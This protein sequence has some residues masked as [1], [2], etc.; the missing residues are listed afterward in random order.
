M[1]KLIFISLLLGI[2]TACFSQE[3][4]KG[5]N[6]KPFFGIKAGVN[7]INSKINEKDSKIFFGYQIGTTLNIPMSDKFS[8]QPELAIQSISNGY[9]YKNEY[10]NGYL[11]EDITYRYLF[12][13]IPLDFKYAISKKVNIDFGPNIAY[14]LSN[15]KK[16]TYEENLDGNFYSS[17]SVKNV[18]SAS[19]K[20]NFGANLGVNYNFNDKVYTGLRYTLFISSYQNIRDTMSNSV[21]ALSVG[22]NFN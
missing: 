6:N 13:N 8:F 10:S 4:E 11:I 9:Y 16:A 20:V 12:I 22:Y 17:S 2:T 1:K 7:I 21:F 5:K 15:K 14:L 19:K 18:T 3:I